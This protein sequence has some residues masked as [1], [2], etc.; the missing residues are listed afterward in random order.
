MQDLVKIKIKGIEY[1][2]DE[3]KSIYLSLIDVF[4]ESAGEELFKDSI[5][6]TKLTNDLGDICS[7]PVITRLYKILKKSQITTIQGLS[8]LEKAEFS[9]LYKVGGQTINAAETYLLKNGSNFK[10]K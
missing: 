5:T 1:S 6:I 9:K 7:K 4:K 8:R 3:A 2:V 10:N